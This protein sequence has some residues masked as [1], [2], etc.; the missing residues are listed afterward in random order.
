MIKKIF[1]S[2][3][4]I[5]IFNNY[6]IAKEKISLEDLLK[7]ALESNLKIKSFKNKKDIYLSQI[8]SASAINNP[9]F[10]TDISPPQKTY[11][12]GINQEIEIY[13]KRKIR[14]DEANKNKELY[15]IELNK[16]INEIKFDIKNKF[17]DIVFLSLKVSKYNELIKNFSKILEISIKKEMSG[18]IPIIDVN[19]FELV[20]LNLINEREDILNKLNQ[21]KIS[22]NEIVGINVYDYDIEEKN[23]LKIKNLDKIDLNEVFNKNIEIFYFNKLKEL[24][25]IQKNKI[26]SEN[27][28]NFILGSGID[29]VTENQQQI[30][31]GTFINLN[32]SIPIFYKKDGEIKEINSKISQIDFEIDIIKQ[33]IKI[34][35]SSY[36]E[37]LKFLKKQIDIYEKEILPKSFELINKSKK[38]FQIGKY[39]ILKLLLFHQNYIQNELKYIEI[40]HEY[41]K[42]VINLEREVYN[43]II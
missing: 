28:P 19:Q 5:L 42:N 20:Y 8:I 41:K 14:I 24:F 40:V 22:I 31:F 30:N 36:L 27:T 16:L 25:S 21:E 39:G 29:I 38:A 43:E 18:D 7:V 11:R 2:T 12:F 37:R 35:I 4:I 34:K 23:Y 26:I 3:F 10:N 32:A 33:S 17:N 15:E 13:D 6:V 1:L 9:V